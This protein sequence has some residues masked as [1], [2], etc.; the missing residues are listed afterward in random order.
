MQSAV[1][2]AEELEPDPKERT[3]AVLRLTEGL[4][5]GH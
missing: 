1:E 5:G 2:E 4:V 3:M